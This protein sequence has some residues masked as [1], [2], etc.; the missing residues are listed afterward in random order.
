VWPR[1]SQVARRTVPV[2]LG[3]D[4]AY[5]LAWLAG[6]SSRPLS[7]PHQMSPEV[8]ARIVALRREHPGWGPDTV[9]CWLTLRAYNSCRAAPGWSAARPATRLEH[10]KFNRVGPPTR[11]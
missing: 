7:C 1:R 9:L 8:E 11:H 10:E 3:R 6:K 4:A 2:W 5:G